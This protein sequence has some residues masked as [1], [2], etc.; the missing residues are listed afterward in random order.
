[1]IPVSYEIVGP[2]L[3]FTVSIDIHFCEILRSKGMG[4]VCPLQ[5]EVLRDQA[6]LTTLEASSC[7]T[8]VV[9]SVGRRQIK[10]VPVDG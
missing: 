9:L 5:Q 10:M 1:M 7:Y 3:F 6:G 2:W 8:F 4:F